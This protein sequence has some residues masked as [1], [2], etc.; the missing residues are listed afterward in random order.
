M[1]RP[2]EPSGFVPVH[3]QIE[4]TWRCNWRCVH[5][6]Q[7]DHV[8]QRL[9]LAR[10]R[11][12][13]GEMAAAGT[14]HVIVTGGEPLARRDIF[15]ILEAIRAR[16]MGITLYTNG[17]LIN[18]NIAERLSAYVGSTE[19][20]VLAG[21]ELVHDALTRVAGSFQ[22]VMTAITELRRR[23]VGVIVKTPLMK[24]ALGTMRALEQTMDALGVEWHVDPEISRT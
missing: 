21:E 24:P 14:M 20:S 17:H 11:A 23:N 22:R 5:C 7:D 1:I 4:V 8:A 3:V 13:F 6:Y 2:H 18:A 19:I 10:L 15:E 12:L 9:D 16:G